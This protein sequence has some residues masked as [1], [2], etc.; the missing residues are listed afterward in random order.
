MAIRY[1]DFYGGNDGNS[2]LTFALRK[3][4][5]NQHALNVGDEIRD[6]ASPSPTSLGVT[7][8]WT[9]LSK[10][11]VL[12]SAVTLDISDCS[13]AWTALTN[14][15]QSQNTTVRKLGAACQ[16][17]VIN[18][19]FTTG[20]VAYKALSNLDFS[21][22]Q[23]I[24]LWFQFSA[25]TIS[26]NNFSIVLCSDSVGAVAVS[27]LNIPALQ[28]TSGWIPLTIDLASALGSG[29]NSVALYRNASI[30]AQ[31]IIIDNI[32]ALKSVSS[33]DSLNLNSLIGKNGVFTEGWYAIKSVS[34]TAVVLDQDVAS[35]ATAGRGYSG[36]TE[37]VTTYKREVFQ[38]PLLAS[39]NAYTPNW[40]AGTQASPCIISGGWNSTDMTT[41]NLGDASYYS[42]RNCKS[43]FAVYTSSTKWSTLDKINLVRYAMGVQ[44]SSSAISS[45]G[46]VLQNMEILSCSS[47]VIVTFPVGITL[48]N[49][50][51]HNIANTMGL[52]IS[53]GGGKFTNITSCN[54]GTGIA[55]NAGSVG[56]TYKNIVCRNNATWGL[57][58]TGSHTIRNLTTSGNTAGGIS[59]QS[60]SYLYDSV[61]SDSLP[62]SSAEI[63][64]YI[65]Y[66]HN[67]NSVGNHL[68]F[69]G[70]LTVTNDITERRTASGY[71][72]KA[73]LVSSGRTSINPSFFKV[74]TI[75]VTENKLLT[76]KIWVKR[77]NTGLNTKFICR[78]DQITGVPND[79]SSSA[80]GVINVYEQLTISF[81]P[82]VSGVV[83]LE[84]Q[85]YATVAN[86]ICYVDD[87]SF[88]S[89]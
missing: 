55:I 72:W 6:M 76:A 39:G 71:C 67:H 81:T 87:M 21:A 38:T 1:N 27:T 33:P 8:T 7:A 83:E 82:T 22:Y 36:T 43:N 88:T 77:T 28:G 37:T 54:N 70:A 84:L 32:F 42:G 23:Q 62:I 50:F 74:A 46:N 29:I 3:K 16:Q 49:I 45:I 5:L 48:N 53:T 13:S 17:F 47:Q 12:S 86:Y 34:G 20:L 25:G 80:V 58:L 65:I 19:T 41:Q 63:Q 51:A 35:I 24:S 10:D 64:D 73:V 66:S 18:G 9:N 30:G 68:I 75:A 89:V 60:T 56:A 57:N 44:F 52:D 14:V 26:A 15:T 61:L 69:T 4:N 40:S 59:N 2:G 31:T 11:I 85:F 78:G 79:V